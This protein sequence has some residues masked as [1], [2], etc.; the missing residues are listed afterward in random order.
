MIKK[1]HKLSS[2][3][4]ENIEKH[5]LKK[6][7]QR[8]LY[9]SF[10]LNKWLFKRKLRKYPHKMVIINM[11]HL[12]GL[13]STF[14]VKESD[15]GFHLK[16]RDYR[17]DSALKYYNVDFGRYMYDF[18]ENLSIP[19]NRK[20]PI[21]ELTATIEQDPSVEIEYMVNPTTLKR[22]VV[23]KIAEGIMQ[24]QDLP[25]AIQRIFLIVGLNL[26]MTIIMLLI[27]LYISGI[28]GEVRSII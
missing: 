27:V 25:K 17:F 23:S 13:H 16:G 4:R 11:E 1:K 21:N 12:N 10:F 22:F 6:K 19:I 8:L 24:G 2:K 18:H 15:G 28:F 26:L 3:E 5:D 7:K 20:I 14:F 9:P